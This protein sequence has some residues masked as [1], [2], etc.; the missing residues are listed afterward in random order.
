MTLGQS[1]ATAA[2]IAIDQN[3]AVQDVP[4]KTLREQLV[5]DRQ[6]L[7]HASSVAPVQQ[8]K[9]VVLPGSKP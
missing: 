6:V 9:G 4:Y 3:L 1:A 2:S 5:K 7:E 8:K